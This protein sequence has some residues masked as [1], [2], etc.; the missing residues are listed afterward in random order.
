MARK[1]INTTTAQSTTETT[2]TSAIQPVRVDGY[3]V[4]RTIDVANP[5]V[6]GDRKVSLRVAIDFTG[7]DMKQLLEWASRT[8]AIDLQRALRACDVNYVASL[9]QNGVFKRRA[10]ECGIGFTD[11][12]KTAAAVKAAVGAMTPEQRAE[13]IKQLTAMM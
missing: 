3:V 5:K 7:V 11:P 2:A 6:W 9:A 12:T 10:S 4:E 1:I 8:K 13:L